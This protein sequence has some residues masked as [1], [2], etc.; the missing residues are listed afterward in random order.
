MHLGITFYAYQ[1][2]AARTADAEGKSAPTGKKPL[3]KPDE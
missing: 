3:T 2:A 1:Q